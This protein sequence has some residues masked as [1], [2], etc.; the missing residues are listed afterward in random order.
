MR[1]EKVSNNI[2]ITMICP[3]PIQTDFL[4]ESFTENSGEVNNLDCLSY[5]L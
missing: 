3:G 5:L 2:A 4:Y 1:T